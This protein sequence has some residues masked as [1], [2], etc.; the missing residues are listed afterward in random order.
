[1]G[2]EGIVSAGEDHSHQAEVG[3]ASVSH[4]GITLP[5]NLY[6]RIDTYWDRLMHGCFPLWLMIQCGLIYVIARIAPALAFGQSSS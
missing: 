1:M 4:F 5:G 3:L 2:R 6:V